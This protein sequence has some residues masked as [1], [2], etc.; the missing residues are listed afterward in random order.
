L[1]QPGEFSA[2]VCVVAHRVFQGVIACDNSNGLNQLLAMSDTPSLSNPLPAGL[3]WYV[4]L[5]KVVLGLAL[6]FWALLLLA[7]LALHFLIVPRIIDWR[8]EIED[9]ASQAWGV[10]VSIGQLSSVSDGLVP[11]FE[12]S[13]FVLR[14]AQGDDVL[15]L[16][17]LRASLSPASLL[18]LSLERIELD[19]PVLEVR[20]NADGAWRVAGIDLGA[21]ESSAFADWLLRQPELRIAQG[22]VR[23]VDDLLQQ[24]PVQWSDV[25]LLMRNGLRSH[26]IRLDANPPPSW[27]QRISLQGE[28]TQAF[29]NRHASDLRTWRGRVYAELPQLELAPWG[30][31]AKAMTGLSIDAGGGWVRV[32]ADWDRGEWLQPG[33][34]L[35]LIGAYT[36]HMREVDDTAMS[37]ARVFVDSRATTVHHIGE[38]ME[39]LKSGA[40]RDIIAD[41]YDDPAL[42]T[43]HS[44]DEITIAKNGGGAHLDLMTATY[45][46]A[47]G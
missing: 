10:Q 40:L 5:S 46:A 21:G 42:F 30:V 27:G 36:P 3:R 37:R 9:A 32:W 12:V 16:P 24:A 31:Y 18:Q 19:G 44:A 35:D 28:F 41:F 14:N 34:H 6:A 39:P 29:L 13:D 7:S 20:R 26:D 45:I 43:R 8:T 47:Q 11:S 38:I 22:Q 1:H 33:Q 25:N 17:K 4:R 2:G 23:W 15:H